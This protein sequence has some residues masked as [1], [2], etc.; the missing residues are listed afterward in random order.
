M[1]IPLLQPGNISEHE[2]FGKIRS[3]L[4]EPYL[5]FLL[6]L[7]RCERASDIV[8]GLLERTLVSKL[9]DREM[10]ADITMEPTGIRS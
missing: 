10:V 6:G 1:T 8:V 7:E 2:R 5:L 4:G 3:G 9:L